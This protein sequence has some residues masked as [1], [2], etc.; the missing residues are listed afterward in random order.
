MKKFLRKI[1]ECFYDFIGD[2]LED[3]YID[4]CMKQKYLNKL[5]KKK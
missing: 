1:K 3:E 5:N 2:M 4:M